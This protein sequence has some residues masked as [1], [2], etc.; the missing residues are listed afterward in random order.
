MTGVIVQCACGSDVE[1]SHEEIRDLNGER[2]TCEAC[3][4]AATV[5]PPEPSGPHSNRRVH[6]NIYDGILLALLDME[7]D[8]GP[9][10]EVSLSS[11]IVEAWTIERAYGLPEWETVFP[12]SNRVV[13]DVVKLVRAGFVDRVKPRPS[14]ERD[15]S[16]YRLTNKGRN[17]ANSLAK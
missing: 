10:V 14:G 5:P 17:R 11:L 12:D 13:M 6:R 9:D 3:R 15:R 4:I 7:R 16:R 2:A 8:L 1:M